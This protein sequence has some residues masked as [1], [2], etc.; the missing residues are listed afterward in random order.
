MIVILCHFFLC[1]IIFSFH[2]HIWIIMAGVNKEENK[3]YWTNQNKKLHQSSC[4]YAHKV[5]MKLDRWKTNPLK[6]FV[7]ISRA[8]NYILDLSQFI[9]TRKRKKESRKW[10]GRRPSSINSQCY[11]ILFG[12]FVLMKVISLAMTIEKTVSVIGS[13]LFDIYYFINIGI[14]VNGTRI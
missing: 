9:W 10:Y 13:M 5:F 4:Q 12:K 6:Q 7:S 8:K 1:L 14:V 11:K 3:N 2:Q